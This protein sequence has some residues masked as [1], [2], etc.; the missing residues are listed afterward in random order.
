MR[1]CTE[2]F[3]RQEAGAASVEVVLLMAVMAAVAALIAV[4]ILGGVHGFAEDLTL[5]E[6]AP[7]R[8]GRP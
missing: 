8:A 4:S 6:L 1:R 3:L 5:N 2:C 7:L